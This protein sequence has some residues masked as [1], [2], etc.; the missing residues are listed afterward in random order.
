MVIGCEDKVS[1]LFTSKSNDFHIKSESE[2]HDSNLDW[3]GCANGG[4]IGGVSGVGSDC[5]CATST[6]QELQDLPA[7]PR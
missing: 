5:A 3:V 7:L 1:D 2:T 4:G 6:W